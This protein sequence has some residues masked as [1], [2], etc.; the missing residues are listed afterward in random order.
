MN[1]QMMLFLTG[2]M[3]TLVHSKTDTVFC[4][5]CCWFVHSQGP[6]IFHHYLFSSAQLAQSLAHAL[7]LGGSEK[8]LIYGSCSFGILGRRVNWK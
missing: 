5:F 7:C 8:I 3:S 2:S 6:P 4:L 1:G